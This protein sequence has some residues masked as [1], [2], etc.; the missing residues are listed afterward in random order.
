LFERVS[1]KAFG[2]PRKTT[3]ARNAPTPSANTVALRMKNRRCL[4]GELKKFVRMPL[5]DAIALKTNVPAE[6]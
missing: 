6:S 3:I 2:V 1:V 4:R 5:G